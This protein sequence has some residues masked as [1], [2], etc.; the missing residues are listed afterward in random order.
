M[1]FL[2]R[3]LAFPLGAL[4]L[5]VACDGASTSPP[6][7][8][9]VIAVQAEDE[10]SL[11]ELCEVAPSARD[12]PVLTW[13]ELASGAAPGAPREA[14]WINVWATWC[15]PCVE[16]I[17]LLTSWVARLRGEGSPV[18]LV[19]LSADTSDEVVATFRAEHPD[20][21]ASLRVAS[22]EALRAWVASVGLD[23]GAG[24][25]LHVFTDA[26]GRVRCARSGAVS[27]EDYLRIRTLLA[28]FRD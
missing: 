7:P 9:R 20:T 27:E 22:P 1:T 18:E 14:R 26:R 15:R 5:L 21:P 23:A 13:P 8:S 11:E 10:G 6:P 19:L 17:P 16:E 3:T 28:S 4:L 25:P 12:A 24:L 2:R